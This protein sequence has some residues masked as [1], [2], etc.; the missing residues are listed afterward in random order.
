MECATDVMSEYRHQQEL[1][2]RHWRQIGA[3]ER[4]RRRLLKDEAAAL[5]NRLI[6]RAMRFDK[7]NDPETRKTQVERTLAVIAK[8]TARS[9]RREIAYYG[10]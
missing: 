1:L 8:A 6:E 4:D 9:H 5:L 3:E 2:R 10:H 7:H